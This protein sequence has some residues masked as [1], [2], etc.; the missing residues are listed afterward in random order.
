MNYNP[1]CISH[2][3]F[4]GREVFLILS[5]SADMMLL[6]LLQAHFARWFNNYRIVALVVTVLWGCICLAAASAAA[7]AALAIHFCLLQQKYC[8]EVIS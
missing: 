4:N 2:W 8:Y 6:V 1:K 7:A 5:K 3:H